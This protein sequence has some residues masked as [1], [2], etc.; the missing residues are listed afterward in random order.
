MT[1][2]TKVMF[3]QKASLHLGLVTDVTIEDEHK[4][5]KNNS[6]CDTNVSSHASKIEVKSEG[7][8]KCIIETM[9][10]PKRMI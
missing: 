7:C 8:K 3:H 5:I 10:N 1:S 2:N 4:H 9:C 6:T